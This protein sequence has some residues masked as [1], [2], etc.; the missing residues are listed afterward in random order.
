MLEPLKSE[1]LDALLR[2]DDNPGCNK[3]SAARHFFGEQDL[4]Q[5]VE[6]LLQA[7]RIFNPYLL[8]EEKDGLRDWNN[9]HIRFYVRTTASHKV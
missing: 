8:F 4:A 9:W 3:V 1:E 6:A 5:G 2:E 7:F